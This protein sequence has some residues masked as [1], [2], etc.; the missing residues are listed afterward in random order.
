MC[1]EEHD[2]EQGFTESEL[3]LA[4]SLATVELTLATCYSYITLA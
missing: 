2:T 4:Q 1:Y 3:E